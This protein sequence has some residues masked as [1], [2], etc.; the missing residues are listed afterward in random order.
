MNGKVCVFGSFNVDLV[1]RVDRFPYPGESLVA[2]SSMTSA[3]GKGANQASAALR[4]GANVHYIGKIGE[5]AFGPF[6]RRYLKSVGYNALTLLSSDETAT[7]NALIF[8]AEGKGEAENMISVDPGANMTI[9]DEEIT[10]CAPAISCADTLLVQLENNMSAISRVINIGRENGAFVILNPAPWQPI[11]NSLLEKIDLVTPNASE[12][13]AM[14]GVDV[15]DFESAGKAAD[16]LHICGCKS[17][18]I[19]MGSQGALL[20]QGMR[21]TIIPCFPAQPKDT[22]GAGDAFNGA[23]AAKIANGESME[24]AIN[25]ASAYAAVSVEKLGASSPFDISEVEQRLHSFHKEIA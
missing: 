3:G 22:T 12:A 4:S 19:T 9:T 5:D 14:T 20:S 24:D 25:F 1:A 21:K 11:N 7:G 10:R 6:A 18:I 8:V 13:F 2:N 23:L 16:V 17:V 15:T